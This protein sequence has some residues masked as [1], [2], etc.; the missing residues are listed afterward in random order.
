[1]AVGEYTV[2]LKAEGHSGVEVVEAMDK[3]FTVRI[4]SK[5]SITGTAILVT[6][7]VVLVLGIA[8]ASVKISRR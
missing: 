4:A 8:I 2:K 6:V 3:N 5:S 1:M 7:L